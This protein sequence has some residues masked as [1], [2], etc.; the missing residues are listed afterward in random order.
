MLEKVRPYFATVERR[1]F[2]YLAVV[3]IA[4]VAAR[5]LFFGENLLLNTR[6][7]GD[8][9]F[10]LQRVQQLVVALADGHFPAR[11]MPDA[12]YGY[13]YPFFNYYAPLSIY[14]AALFRFMG[15]SFVR[16][17]QLAQIAGFLLA[18][19]AAFELAARWFKDE[20]AGLLAAA[21]YTVA[22]FHMVNV[23]VRGDS[24]AEFWAMALYPVVLL[25]A[26]GALRR[27]R[28]ED[29][30]TMR[31]V[32]SL[33]LLGLSY[34]ALVLCHNI[35][36]LIFSP[37]VLLYVALLSWRWEGRRLEA[38]LFAAGGLLLGLALSAWFWVPALGESNLVQTG[39]V[40]E[41]YFH[42]SNHFLSRDLVQPSLF[43]DFDVADRAAFRMGLLQALLAVVGGGVLLWQAWRRR[44]ELLFRSR[45]FFVLALLLVAT[46]MITPLSAPLWEHLPLLPFVQFPWR[47]LSIQA[48]GT[49]LV[50]G[51]LAL[52]PWRRLLVPA[53][54]AL[55]L[56]AML[57][58]L[59]PDYLFLRDEDVTSERLAQYEWFTGNIGTTVSAEYLPVQVQPRPYTSPW[60]ERGVRDWAQVLAGEAQVQLAERR[61][62][63]Q[64][65]QIQA[66]AE[67]ATVE[68]PTL[69]WPGWRAL[70]DGEEVDL[71]PAGNS[72]LITV[73][74]PPGEHELRLYLGR[75]PLRAVAEGVSLWALLLVLALIIFA[76]IRPVEQ[77]PLR[78]R[79]LGWLVTTFLLLLLFGLWPQQDARSMPAFTW[80]FAQMGYLSRHPNGI[81][82]ED[83]TRLLAYDYS[84]DVVQAGDT[85]QIALHWA[86]DGTA[87][88][89]TVLSLETPAVHRF[90]AA[91]RLQVAE[92]V[93]EGNPVRYELVIPANAPAGL[94]VPRLQRENA[95]AL[96]FPGQQ[97]RG[98]L[99]LQPL[100]VLSNMPTDPAGERLQLRVDNV[101]LVGSAPDAGPAG[102]YDC[103]A[104]LDAPGQLLVELAWFTPHA[105]PDNYTASLRLTGPSGALYAQCDLQPGYGFNPSGSWPAGQW[106]PDRLALPLPPQLPEQQSYVL[107]VVLYEQPGQAVL[108]RRLGQVAFEGQ[109]LAFRPVEP[110]YELPE[111][112]E[113]ARA[114]FDDLFLLRG[115]ELAQDEQTL[116]LTLYW[117]SLAPAVEDYV[118]FVHLVGDEAQ[119]PVAQADGMPDANSYPTSQWS[120]GEIVS[121]RVVMNL[122]EVP[123]GEYQ[124]A[125]GFY[126]PADPATRLPASAEDGQPLAGNRFLLPV[127]VEK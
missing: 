55:L 115:Y 47:F 12:A 43:F 97:T 96:T 53:L 4:L 85:V 123:P 80:D 93:G 95:Q 41:G 59:S 99:F 118:R 11:W 24:L 35:S 26:D 17:I 74:V 75:T 92:R 13:G 98:D 102:L 20:W 90:S 57:G 10:L 31:R 86:E 3:A 28:K 117:E 111:T 113:V 25:A 71:A 89:D 54:T 120:E 56:A 70:V 14:V 81:P 77:F 37:F 91:P 40:T 60:L 33:A 127:S 68:L 5:P 79:H 106:A 64:R 22:P 125:V 7:G 108:T 65:W 72:G 100:R 23:Y 67:G 30:S 104:R 50:T 126:P 52:L 32:L 69:F 103:A 39:P 27:G 109:E 88:D 124:L 63:Q 38:L 34:G 82:F 16:A 87:V 110:S 48:L 19:W 36:A 121:D 105:L 49:S 44:P 107:A 112:A 6:G 42:F 1:T 78:R 76:L 2:F 122:E 8:S 61:A 51:A 58:N 29:A 119:P 116:S 94:Y 73:Q 21:A 84:E 62:T 15:F 83:G 114:R 101:S 66:G 9:P 46:F 18:A 45:A